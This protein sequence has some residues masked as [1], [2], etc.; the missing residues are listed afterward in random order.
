MAAIWRQFGGNFLSTTGNI[1]PQVETLT[2]KQKP[3]QS[4]LFQ[5]IT[6]VSV[7]YQSVTPMGF[8]PMTFRTGIYA[9]DFCNPLIISSFYIFCLLRGGNL[10]AIQPYSAHTRIS[11]FVVFFQQ[12]DKPV[13]LLILSFQQFY[14]TVYRLPC[15]DVA[16][17]TH[18]LHTAFFCVNGCA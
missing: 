18:H 5:I 9:S 4:S 11:L 2:T 6:R 1:L 12:T 15:I 14:K 17:I 7:N 10:A 8:K 16:C 13:Y 3:L